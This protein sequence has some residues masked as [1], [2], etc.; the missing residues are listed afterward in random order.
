MSGLMDS[1]PQMPLVLSRTQSFTRVG[2]EVN[3]LSE[4]AHL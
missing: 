4:R 2:G 1:K 3:V